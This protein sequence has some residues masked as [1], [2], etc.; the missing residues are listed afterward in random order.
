MY[1]YSKFEITSYCH[2]ID[3]GYLQGFEQRIGAQ[4][5]ESYKA[6]LLRFGACYLTSAKINLVAPD[7]QVFS[8][9]PYEYGEVEVGVFYA[10]SFR[11]TGRPDNG[12]IDRDSLNEQ[13][14]EYTLDYG[15]DPDYIPIADGHANNIFLMKVKGEGVGSVYYWL[16]KRYCLLAHSFEA[17]LD[18]LPFVKIQTL[19]EYLDSVSHLIDGDLKKLERRKTNWLFQ[20]QSSRDRYQIKEQGEP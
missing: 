13:Y 2:V 5:P 8:D 17:F 18:K 7:G 11:E 19:E 10:A 4:L 12:L 3:Q 9:A 14:E 1:D 6:F 20:Q 15:L 16:N